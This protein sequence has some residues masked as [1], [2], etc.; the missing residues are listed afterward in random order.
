MLLT[1]I[2]VL[3]AAGTRSLS[4]DDDEENLINLNSQKITF[5]LKIFLFIFIQNAIAVQHVV[6]SLTIQIG[7]YFF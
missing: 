3:S 2:P 5:R 6:L 4:Y 1:D 7:K